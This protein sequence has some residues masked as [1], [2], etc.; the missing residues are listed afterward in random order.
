MDRR[1]DMIRHFPTI[2]AR[3]RGGDAQL[4][5]IT[6]SHPTLVILVIKE[7]LAGC[8]IIHCSVPRRIEAPRTWKD[9]EFMVRKGEEMFDLVDEAANAR[10]LD[11][12]VSLSEHPKKPWES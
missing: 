3:W 7:E 11:C 10:I 2:L 6:T 4:W 8:L 5:N 9:C 1:D 12:G